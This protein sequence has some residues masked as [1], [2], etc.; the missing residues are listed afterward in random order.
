MGIKPIE[1]EYNGYRFRSRLE[2][3]W[4]VFFDAAGIPY[5]YEPEG[6]NL[7]GDYYL[8][9]FY[10]PWFKC[11]IEI[12]PNNISDNDKH[13]AMTKLEAL[14]ELDETCCCMLCIGDPMDQNMELICNDIT[15]SSGGTSWWKAKWVEGAEWAIKGDDG[16]Y[17]ASSGKHH[18]DIGLDN[19]VDRWFY[20]SNWEELHNLMSLYSPELISYR[21]DLS[22][23]AQKARQARFEHGEKPKYNK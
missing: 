20:S 19:S 17:F 18:I 9:D 1:T 13:I 3:R 4:A 22:E 8:P 14:F 11:Y 16:V 2:A 7:K 15:D 23:Y 10:L 12:K 21:S 6:Y 5:Q